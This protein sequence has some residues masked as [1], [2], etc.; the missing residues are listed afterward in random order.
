MAQIKNLQIRRHSLKE[1]GHIS[2]AGLAKLQSE[3]SL[4]CPKGISD[5]FC[6]SNLGRTTQSALAAVCYHGVKAKV[7]PID[8]RFGSA[9]LFSAWSTIGFE[10]LVCNSNNPLLA[11]KKLLGVEALDSLTLKLGMAIEDAFEKISRH[12][13]IYGHSPL[14]EL[15]AEIFSDEPFDTQLE[16]NEGILLVKEG[17]KINLA[18]FLN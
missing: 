5:V 6:G 7:H 1:D 17:Y 11:L 18:M 14:I 16:P 15:I 3:K 8:T 9:E 10:T 13:L 12:G 4:I 2:S